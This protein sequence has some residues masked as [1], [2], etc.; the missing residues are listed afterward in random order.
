MK[1][2]L[3][4]VRQA[5]AINSRGA[6]FIFLAILFGFGA[7]LPLATSKTFKN[8]KAQ[9]TQAAAKGMGAITPTYNAMPD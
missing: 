6:L 2:L 4:R 3:Q 7:A 8:G 5:G 1:L 9:P